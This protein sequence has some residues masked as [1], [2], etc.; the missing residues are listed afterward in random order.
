MVADYGAFASENKGIFRIGSVDCGDFTAICSKEK[1]TK[2]PTVRV[3]PTF[4][5]PLIDL[6]MGDTFNVK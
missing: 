1:I 6:E 3:Y 5:A 4:P 2:F